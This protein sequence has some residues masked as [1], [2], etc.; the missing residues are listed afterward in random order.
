MI[1]VIRYSYLK[2]DESPYKLV[3]NKGEN[4][5]LIIIEEYSESKPFVGY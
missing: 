3:L 5:E 1:E 2:K 4:G